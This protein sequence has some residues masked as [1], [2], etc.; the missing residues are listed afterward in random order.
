MGVKQ[1]T[2]GVSL[3]TNRRQQYASDHYDDRART[4]EQLEAAMDLLIEQA[5]CRLL[6]R[7]TGGLLT[8][9]GDRIIAGPAGRRMR[10]KEPAAP[11][12]D[13]MS[14]EHESSRCVRPAKAGVYEY[15]KVLVAR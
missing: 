12:E 10:V 6:E 5:H 11:A 9:M 2:N 4:E 3:G 15:P 7:S 13:L 14:G 1:R 8:W